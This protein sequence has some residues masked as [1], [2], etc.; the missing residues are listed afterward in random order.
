M[1]HTEEFRW[2]VPALGQRRSYLSTVHLTREEA[3][4]QYGPAATPDPATRRERVEPETEAERLN[5]MYHYQSAGHDSVK[6]PRKD[7][8]G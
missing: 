6:P 8:N 2:K 5:A 4:K 7:R 1:R 3:L